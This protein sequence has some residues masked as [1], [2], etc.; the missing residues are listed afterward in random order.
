MKEPPLRGC[1]RASLS[2]LESLTTIKAGYSSTLAKDVQG[3]VAPVNWID[4]CCNVASWAR[5][6]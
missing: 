1:A 5:A 2:V 4:D 3:P 6:E